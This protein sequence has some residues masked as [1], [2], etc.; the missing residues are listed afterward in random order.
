MS[1]RE[2]EPM[3]ADAARMM[4][5][6]R[7]AY[8]GDTIWELLIRARLI[9]NGY[10]V[11]HMHQEAVGGVN[12]AAQAAALRRIEY[13]L[14]EEELAIVHRGRN[15]HSRHHAPRHQHP[16]DYQSA[17]ALEA[18]VGYLYLTGQE[19]RLMELF[20]LSQSEEAEVC[21]TSN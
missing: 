21:R 13:A 1:L 20:A 14:S 9:A 18:L 11:R 19:K 7:M 17:T 15:A 5:P 10:T 4:N 8:M 6:L 12:A 2:T 3:D 16:A